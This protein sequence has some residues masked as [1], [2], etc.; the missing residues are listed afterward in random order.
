MPSA[1]WKLLA[2]TKSKK[3]RGPRGSVL[4]NPLKL[5]LLV[6]PPVHRQPSEPFATNV[7]IR[8]SWN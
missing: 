3:K 8:G 7:V 1:T 6:A 4:S 2:S 5:P